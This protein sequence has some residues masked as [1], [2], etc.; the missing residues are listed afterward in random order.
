M[1][2]EYGPGPHDNRSKSFF[3]LNWA[4]HEISM[5]D[6]SCLINLLEELFI[7]KEF[8]CFCPS[9]QTYKFDFLYTLK[10]YVPTQLFL[11]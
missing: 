9:N 2:G 8:H 3:M 10:C 1:V 5:L 6:K 4:E 7:Y 11:A